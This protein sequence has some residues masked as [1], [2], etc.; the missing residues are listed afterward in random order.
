M[1]NLV[2]TYKVIMFATPGFTPGIGDGKADSSKCNVMAMAVSFAILWSCSVGIMVM[3]AMRILFNNC[4][5][6]ALKFWC[7]F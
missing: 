5:K 6:K 2:K 3:S 1:P 7:V 4:R